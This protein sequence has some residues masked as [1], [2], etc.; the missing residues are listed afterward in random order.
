MSSRA[1]KSWVIFIRI[2]GGEE[3]ILLGE[4][5]YKAQAKG[6]MAQFVQILY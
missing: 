4:A 2:G 5:A 3:T 6:F 1:L